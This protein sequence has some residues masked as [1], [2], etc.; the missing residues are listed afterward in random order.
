MAETAKQIEAAVLA[1]AVVKAAEVMAEKKEKNDK[2]AS[3]F[4]YINTV[5]LLILAIF[6]VLTFNNIRE[7]KVKQ[8]ESSIELIRIK[9]VQDNNTLS[10]SNLNVRVSAIEVNALDELKTW[11]EANFVRKNN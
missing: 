1:E 2:K 6:S 7:V 5:I 9:T 10:I 4:Q 8:T 11:T 3:Y